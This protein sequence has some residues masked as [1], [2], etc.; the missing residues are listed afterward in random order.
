MNSVWSA[1]E[2][3]PELAAVREDW[4]R[5]CGEHFEVFRKGF[6]SKTDRT[7]KAYPCMD[8]CQTSHRLKR[9]TNGTLVALC[10]C[11]EDVDCEDF[12]VS[13]EE[14]RVWELNVSRLGRAVAK[15]FNGVP[16]EAH[17][18]LP[19]TWQIGEFGGLL[20]IVMTFP[21]TAEH[22]RGVA[23]EL[24]ARFGKG[25]IVLTLSRR[26]VDANAEALLHGVGA[27]L[28]D[29]SA[30]L[31]LLPSGAFHA[32]KSGGELF[33]PY[34]PE[35]KESLREEEAKQFVSLLR[36]LRSE[37]AGMKAPLYDVFVAIVMDDC[38][39]RAAAKRC[40]CSV[41]IIAKRTAELEARFGRKLKSIQATARESS[42]IEETVKGDKLRKKKSG[43]ADKTDA[44]EG[45]SAP[46]EVY[47]YDSSDFA[48]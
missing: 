2:E 9:R 32:R 12:A 23:A 1:I 28:F 48:Q 47:G 38:T 21:E 40:D 42:E 29:M 3:L 39:V 10:A 5:R 25:L 43:A 37:R 18:G 17:L 7:A 24:A 15:A 30:E 13:E 4:R 8:R 19:A 35:K 34:L 31:R 36:Q 14:A 22:F 33:T 6:L 26:F 20:K 11:D 27:G 46:P 16:K 45:D 44:E 41:G